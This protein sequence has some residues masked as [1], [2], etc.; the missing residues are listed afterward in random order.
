[1]KKVFSVLVLSIFV[2]SFAY[3]GMD[4]SKHIGFSLWGGGV[5]SVSGN[6]DANNKLSDVVRMYGFPAGEIK[7]VIIDK[8]ALGINGGYIYQPFKDE[9]TREFY[10]EQ[11]DITP[12]LNMTFISLNGTFN[13][14]PLMKSENNMFNP[15]ATLGVG[16]YSWYFAQNERT[17]KLHAPA[18][19]TQD[20]KASSLGIN[21]GAG[22]EYFATRKFSVFGRIN[23]HLVMMKDEKKFGKDFGSHGFLAFGAG[24]T[25]YLFTGKQ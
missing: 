13:F 17:D 16:M 20:F 15:F 18:D 5:T 6:Y 12:A 8:M 25:L 4:M 9:K 7:Y 21:F 2:S 3:G 1:V 23:Y 11:K 24:V 19:S 14:G 10:P 22:A